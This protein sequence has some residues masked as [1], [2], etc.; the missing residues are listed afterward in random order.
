MWYTCPVENNPYFIRMIDFIKF[1]AFYNAKGRRV[2]RQVIVLY[3]YFI[4]E[5][6]R[7]RY[8]RSSAFH[9]IRNSAVRTA[10][11]KIH[12]ELILICCIV[13]MTNSCAR[14]YL[15]NFYAVVCK[16][17]NAVNACNLKLAELAS[18]RYLICTLFFTYI[19][20]SVR[21][22]SRWTSTLCGHFI[23]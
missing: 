5:A 23:A 2:Q 3:S 21:N 22:K 9:E 4:R 8:S 6:W 13:A 7:N 14:L 15:H 1:F 12:S 16:L 20:F 19:F 10:I 17:Y 11:T 18:L